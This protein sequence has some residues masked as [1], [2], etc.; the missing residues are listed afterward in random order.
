[1]NTLQT[2]LTAKIM[3]GLFIS[4][5]DLKLQHNRVVG[6]LKVRKSRKKLIG[7]TLMNGAVGLLQMLM[8]KS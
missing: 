1:M 6:L 3:Y 2:I 7:S 4:S 8:M 5:D